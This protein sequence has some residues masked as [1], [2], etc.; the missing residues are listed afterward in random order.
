[1][2]KAG[3]KIRIKFKNN[4]GVC[5]KHPTENRYITNGDILTVVGIL[6]W[7][8]QKF[9][10]FS[11]NDNHVNLN[12]EYGLSNLMSLNVIH[13]EP[14]DNTLVA[15]SCKCASLLFGHDTGCPFNKGN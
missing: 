14:V 3:D 9:I 4:V 5:L 12:N 7:L 13:C 8:D 11:H 10:L 1:M 2:F 6:K 15:T